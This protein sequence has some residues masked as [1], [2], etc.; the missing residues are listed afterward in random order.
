MP[1]ESY[2]VAI[3]KEGHGDCT[4]WS[5]LNESRKGRVCK[6]VVACLGTG[7]LTEPP[8]FDEAQLDNDSNDPDLLDQG[9]EGFYSDEDP[10]SR[11]WSDEISFE[12]EVA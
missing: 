4:C 11:P 3:T 8:A 10:D 1:G 6:H 5:F 12:Q 2:N 7:L 9:G